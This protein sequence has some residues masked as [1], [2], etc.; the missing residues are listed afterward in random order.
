LTKFGLYCKLVFMTNKMAAQNES[1]GR[2]AAAYW[3]EDGLPEL[4][5]GLVFLV[6]FLVSLAAYLR[7]IPFP[8]FGVLW[9]A[10]LVVLITLPAWGWK[11]LDFIKTRSTYPRSGYAVP[12]GDPGPD[13]DFF[14]D[15]SG[16]RKPASILTLRPPPPL[17]TNVTNF[18]FRLLMILAIA[19][20]LSPFCTKGW[21]VALV[22]LAM[23]AVLY[24]ITRRDA[25]SYS[26][27]SVL[28]VALAGLLAAFL[29]LPPDIRRLIP[30]LILSVWLIVRGSWLL[31]RFLRTHP[32]LEQ[33]DGGRL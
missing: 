32:R 23:A 13:Q 33:M 25:H 17:K 27:V 20:F 24:L 4:L 18:R 10:G 16:K 7:W 12:P 30:V 21:A 5:A 29:D 26:W 2:R 8:L 28:P 22:T 6:C 14:H 11:V 3:F 31:V 15:L 1:P 19:G 9:S